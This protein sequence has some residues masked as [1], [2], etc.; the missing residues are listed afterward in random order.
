MDGASVGPKELVNEGCKDGNC[1]GNKE[2][3]AEGCKDGNCVGNKEGKTDGCKDGNCV[4]NNEGCTEG[5]EVSCDLALSTRTASKNAI[6]IS[7]YL[8]Y[9][10]DDTTIIFTLSVKSEEM[11]YAFV[12]VG[13]SFSERKLVNINKLHVKVRKLRR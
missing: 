11:H 2:G 4:G 10:L 1:D 12:I 5:D 9:F 13:A 8:K 6:S 7:E 3:K